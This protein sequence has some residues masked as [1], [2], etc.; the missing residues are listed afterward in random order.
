[1]SVYSA[2]F[3][4]QAVCK[5]TAP[6]VGDPCVRKGGKELKSLFYRL[7]CLVSVFTLFC[8]VCTI[9]AFSDDMCGKAASVYGY[10]LNDEMALYGALSVTEPN[11]NIPNGALTGVYP[12]G[13]IYADIINFDN[14][15]NPYLVIFRADSG[16]PGICADV[17]RYDEKS[18]EAAAVTTLSRSYSAE[19]GVTGEFALGFNDTDRYIIYNEYLDGE[20]ISSDLYTMINGIAYKRVE[21]PEYV[22]EAGIVG[23]CGD[24]IYPSVDLTGYNHYL[25]DFFSSLKNASAASVTYEDIY[26]RLEE[27]EEN[28]IEAVLTSAAKFSF[29]DIGNCADMHAYDTALRS[30][31]ADNVFYSITNLYD[32]GEEM[33]YVRFATNKSFYNYAILRRT[34]SIDEGYQ[35]LAVRTDSIPLSDVELESYRDVYSRNKLLYKKAKGSITVSVSRAKKTFKTEE[36]GEKPLSVPK[37]VNSSLRRPLG[38]IGGGI[39]LG[40]IVLFWIIMASDNDEK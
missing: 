24:M 17:Y 30:P 26:E 6:A 31:D 35:L 32:L 8:S 37:A 39:C 12:A 14:N 27:S 29:F 36:K 22:R 34:A 28:R 20:R 21:A 7:L 4:G 18:G 10:A 11:E 40:L 3:L 23:F 2:A 16:L 13:V 25:D 5:S 1:M 38:F 19:P 9:R 15:E 33:Y